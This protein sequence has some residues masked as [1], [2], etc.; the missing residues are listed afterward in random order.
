MRLLLYLSIYE[1]IL[2]LWFKICRWTK[3][4]NMQLRLHPP[5]GSMPQQSS[6]MVPQSSGTFPWNF[7]EACAYHNMNITYITIF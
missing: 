7:I 6:Q 5:P 2:P 3:R 4:E 1:A